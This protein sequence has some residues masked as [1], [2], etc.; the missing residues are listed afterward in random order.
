MYVASSRWRGATASLET[1]LH[2]VDD[3]RVHTVET[4]GLRFDARFLAPVEPLPGTVSL[5]VL[6]EGR[7]QIGP[8]WIDTPCWWTARAD[9][10]DKRAPSALAFRL[11]G[12]PRRSIEVCLDIERLH[13]PVGLAHGAHALPRGVRDAARALYG[14]A[15]P[16]ERAARC[17]AFIAALAEHRICTLRA[18]TN[19]GERG[20][21]IERIVGSLVTLFHEQNTGAYGKLLASL[22]GVSVRQATRDVS[23]LARRFRL[24]GA[25]VREMFRVLRL[26]RATMLLGARDESLEDVARAVGYSGLDAMARALRDAGL[27]PPGAIRRALL[28]D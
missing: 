23:T 28:D 14:E 4:R 12:E 15:S 5:F 16:T 26:R 27:P 6:V 9:E 25:S 17:A 19:D 1:T 18:G 2:L 3:A 20:A 13:V 8:A 21:T 7:A 10:F 24:P 22:A 11:E